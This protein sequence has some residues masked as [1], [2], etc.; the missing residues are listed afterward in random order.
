MEGAAEEEGLVGAAVEA[1][2]ALVEGAAEEEG[3]VG[4]AVEAVGLVEGAAEEGLV[5]GA[6]EEVGLVE[7]AA[8]ERGLAAAA[9]EDGGLVGADKGL[10]AVPVAELKA[11][12]VTGILN[13]VAA[14]T[15]W[16][17]VVT[18]D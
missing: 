6:A 15:Y 8:E 18:R 14:M 7:G 5:G 3:L 10:I 1:E 2:E 9:A 4:G 11:L 17:L 13:S 16:D 12:V